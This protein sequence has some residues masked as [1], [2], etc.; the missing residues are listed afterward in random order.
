MR[1]SLFIYLSKTIAETK[2]FLISLT[3]ILIMFCQLII[4]TLLTGF[5]Q[6]TPKKL[7]IKET[8]YTIPIASFLDINLKLYSPGQL[9]TILYDKRHD[10]KFV[11]IIFPQ[12]YSHYSCPVIEKFI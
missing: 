6:Y 4:Q 12:L 11:I 7:E 9:S 8:T 10:L 1:Q 5:Y 3:G 2:V